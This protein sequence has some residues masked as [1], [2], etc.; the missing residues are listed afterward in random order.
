MKKRILSF[1]IAVILIFSSM[2][3][4][5]QAA[6]GGRPGQGGWGDSGS[7]GTYIGWEYSTVS[8]KIQWRI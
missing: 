5:T 3:V 6:P 4:N 1:I 7:Y 8:E 2:P